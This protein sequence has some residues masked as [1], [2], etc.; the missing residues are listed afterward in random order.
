MTMAGRCA[1]GAAALALV[2]SLAGCRANANKPSAASGTPRTAAEALDQA[3]KRLGSVTSYQASVSLSTFVGKERRRLAGEVTS[4]SKDQALEYDVPFTNT[5]WE[6]D[7]GSS[8]ILLGDK[9]YI[10]N[11]KLLEFIHKPWIGLS[12]S[13][14]KPADTDVM[15]LVAQVRQ[16]DPL[17]HARMFTASKDVHTVGR[18]TTA[19]TPTTRYQGTFALSEALTKLSPAERT[20]AQLVYGPFG[21]TPYF[22]VWIDDQRLIRKINLVNRRGTKR[23]LNTTINYSTFDTPVTITP[24]APKDVKNLNHP[25]GIPV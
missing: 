10:K 4:R 25:K 17:L 19:G 11:L 22:E 12:L 20:E 21:T 8:E 16:P 14:L 5:G 7:P 9:L 24:P 2:V 3:V 13:A 23:R 15:A 1:A 18:E 6:G